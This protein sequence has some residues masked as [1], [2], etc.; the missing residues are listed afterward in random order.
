VN[1]WRIYRG[2]G[3]PHDGVRDLPA[4]PPWRDFSPPDPAAGI[5]PGTARRLGVRR[6]LVE[7]HHPRPEEVEAVNAALHLRRPLL[8]T[9]NP[10]TGKST[11]AHAVAHELGLGA[12][13]RWPV[14]SRTALQDGLYRYDAIGRLQDVQL[15]RAGAEGGRWRSIGSYVRLGPLGTALLPADVPRVLLVDELD[16]SDMDLPNDL[17]GVLEEGE[18][19]LPELE[20]IADREPEVEVSTHDGQR[21]VV[22]DGRVR[23]TTFPFIVLTS[24]GERDFPA[25]LL[26]RCI[27]LELAPPGEEQLTA[28]VEA[29]LGEA[30]VAA[31]QDLIQRFLHR[32][33]GEVVAADQLLNALYLT[34]HAARGENVT[35]DRLAEMLM[36]PLDRP[37]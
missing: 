20:R 26:R 37:R 24:N 15:D 3:L 34:R 30:A 19:A 25:A 8:V 22:H 7:N 12:V 36:Q 13:L 14:V 31:G 29:H 27:R 9:G 16:K 35:R 11:L 32:D 17:L 18:F 33:P 5:D 28:M 23:C 10:G 2:T 4:P 6:R 1:D 21:A